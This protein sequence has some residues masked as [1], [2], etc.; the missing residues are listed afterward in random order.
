MSFLTDLIDQDVFTEWQ[1]LIDAGYYRV[2]QAGKLIRNDKVK[3]EHGQEEG[4]TTINAPWI[5]VNPSPDIH[6]SWWTDMRDMGKFIPTKC[7]NCYK[8]V[9]RPRTLQE[10]MQ[11]YQMQLK[12]VEKDPECYCKCGIETRPY[13]F[14]NYG[15]YFYNRGLKQG[16]EKYKQVR[17][18]VNKEIS[19]DVPVTLKRYCTEFERDFGPS[20]FYKQPEDA[21]RFEALIEK[22]AII[23]KIKVDNSDPMIVRMMRRWIQH[24]WS[25]GDETVFLYTD[26]KKMGVDCCTYHEAVGELDKIGGGND[27]AV[28]ADNLEGKEK[29]KSNAKQEELSE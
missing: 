1:P 4:S 23:D 29:E 14:G 24:A 22:H 25:V 9:V 3:D 5:Y 20:P 18:N 17:E 13:V 19:P 10:L 6:C 7:M 21:K 26:G 15:G 28:V 2:T 12:M 11:L 27:E 16:L 8:V